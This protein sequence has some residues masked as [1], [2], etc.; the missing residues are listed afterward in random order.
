MSDMKHLMLFEAFES[1]ALSK[2]MSFLNKNI[3]RDSAELFRDK[4]RG[5]VNRLNIPIDKIK[6]SDV[7]YLNRNKALKIK[8]DEDTDLY[9]LK[10]WFSLEEG[11]LGFT[12]TGRSTMNFGKHLSSIENRYKKNKPFNDDQLDYIKD[13]LSIKTGT[14]TPVKSYKNL[15]H[16]QLVIGMFDGNYDISKISLAK[17]WKEE[18]HLYAIQDVSSGGEPGERVNG[19]SWREW[20]EENSFRYSWSLGNYDEIGSDHK[21]LHIYEPSDEPLKLNKGEIENVVNENP[22]DFNLPLD[23]SY[24]LSEWGD[25]EWSIRGY[26][27]IENSDFSI[28][29]MIDDIIKSTKSK[30]TDVRKSREESK[31]GAIKLM[32]DSNIKDAN[33]KRYLSQLISKMG[34]ST[35]VSNLQNLQ[36]IIIKSVCNEFAFI[37]IF[38][39][40]PGFDYLDYIISDIYNII[41]SDNID[42]KKYNLDRAIRHFRDLNKISEDYN[43]R[44]KASLEVIKNSN[45]PHIKE[46]FDVIMKIGENIKNYLLSQ[47]V[48][49]IEDL[50][51]VVTKLESIEKLS[52]KNEFRFDAIIRVIID[53]FQYTNDVQYRVKSYEGSDTGKDLIKANHLSRYVDSLLK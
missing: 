30:V 24:R 11:Y 39:Y 46:V 41:D 10:F 48:Q 7:K 27:K 26:N 53:E 47:N 34:I 36:K 40:R 23:S 49:T 2:M 1:K 28:V 44:Y 25:D 31:E 20:R 51:M 32:N 8:S 45:N 52:K 5:I 9:C 50:R 12:G 35:D 38:K 42:T 19:V 3:N 37:S 6:D 16:G 13:R 18:D 4:L 21:N 33:I 14:L 22:F 29:L 43:K 17:I 15:Q